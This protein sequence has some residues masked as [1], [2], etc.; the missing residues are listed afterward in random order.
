MTLPPPLDHTADEHEEARCAH[1]HERVAL[2][3]EA[4]R[5]AEAICLD[6][7]ERLTPIRRRVLEALYA[8]HRPVSAYEII[9]AVSPPGKRLAAVTIYRTLDFLMT[10]GFIHRLE[11]RNAFFACPTRHA[12]GDVVVF[13]ICERC[14]GVDEAISDETRDVLSRLTRETGFVPQSRVIELMGSCAHCKG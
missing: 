5:R 4:L 10:H 1:A 12:P 9:D 3:P 11:S 8:T 6:K 13:M 2:A 7:G 14:G